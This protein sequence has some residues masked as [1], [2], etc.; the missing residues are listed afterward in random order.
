MKTSLV[1]GA[2][3]AA[4]IRSDAMGGGKEGYTPRECG[5]CRL[6]S[7]TPRGLQ[8]LISYM[9]VGCRLLL[10]SLLAFVPLHDAARRP[11]QGRHARRRQ[12]GSRSG[13]LES[14]LPAAPTDAKQR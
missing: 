13:P 6:V 3:A 5:V 12:T 7:V 2:S 14:A 10:P 1:G 4:A 11:R 8:Y 9:Y